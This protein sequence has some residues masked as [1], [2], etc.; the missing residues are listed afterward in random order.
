M[1]TVKSRLHI[2]EIKNDTLFHPTFTLTEV[3]DEKGRTTIIER[4][5]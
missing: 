1:R 5:W 4:L 2:V 3:S